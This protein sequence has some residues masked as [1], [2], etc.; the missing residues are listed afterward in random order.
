[1][2]RNALTDSI[3]GATAAI[4]A[5]VIIAPVERVK[6]IYQVERK[7]AQ[8]SITDVVLSVYRNEG[9]KAYWK[10]I[11]AAVG[12]IGPYMGAKF[13]FLEKYKWLC[14]SF[15][16]SN[17]MV[18]SFI[19]GSAAGATA[20]ALTYPLDLMRARMAVLPHH[21]TYRTM[22][23]QIVT[24][25]AGH[26]GLFAGVGVTLKG[27]AVHDAFKF[28]SYD[29]CKAMAVDYFG[30]KNEKELGFA[31]RVLAGAFAGAFAQTVTYPSDIIR[32]RMQTVKPGE[33]PPYTGMIDGVVHIYKHEGIRKGLYRGWTLNMLKASPNIAIYMSMYDFLSQS[34]PSYLGHL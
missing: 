14:T 11:G 1:M 32:R 24:G 16:P 9:I 33:T 7:Q 29:T 4:T 18:T 8:S 26:K 3:A 25:S 13:M 21:T 28:S 5:R 34:L 20:T 22:Y 15:I 27:I 17:V 2:S 10:G 19:A 31:S 23:K 30:V 12:R 6:I